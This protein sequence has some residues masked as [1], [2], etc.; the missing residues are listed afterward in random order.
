[1]VVRVTDLKIDHDFEHLFPDVV[2]DE[3]DNL[4]ENIRKHGVMDSI[5]TWNGFIVDG[6]TRIRICKELGIEEVHI[7]E[8]DFEKKSEAMSFMLTYQKGRR[9][10]TPEQVVLAND[11]IKA[12]LKR[13]AKERQGTR[14]DLKNNIVANLPESSAKPKSDSGRVMEQL[15]KNAGKSRHTYEGMEYVVHNGDKGHIERLNKGESVSKLVRE[16]RALKQGESE[17]QCPKCGRLLPISE[18]SS[19]GYCKK[20]DAKTRDANRMKQLAKGREIITDDEL[21]EI[22]RNAV[23]PEYT[24]E[25]LKE[26]LISSGDRLVHSFRLSKDIHKDVL[27]TEDEQATFD[28][29][30]ETICKK[31]RELKWK[32]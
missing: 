6:H 28:E 10:M 16:V 24:I 7:A 27:R 9:K 30:I 17:K 11:R 3:Y 22:T 14:N 13:E 1:M 23:A 15:A 25:S 19:N 12:Q 18:I 4:K 32:Q 31:M 8:M 20:C 29:I 21:Y 2:G 5:K 26:E